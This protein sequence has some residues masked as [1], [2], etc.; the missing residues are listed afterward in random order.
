[1]A[2]EA[3][4]MKREYLSIRLTSLILGMAPPHIDDVFFNWAD[5][6]EE[7]ERQPE[8]WRLSLRRINRRLGGPSFDP[9]MGWCRLRSDGI[10][11]RR[12]SCSWMMP[13][14]QFSDE[15]FT[16]M[17]STSPVAPPTPPP[18]A[19]PNFFVYQRETDTEEHK[20]KIRELMP[21]CLNK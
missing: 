13:S 5:E 2:K 4:K 6:P 21:S 10:G 7:E 11:D 19:L 18:P 9:R 14:S 16:S 12:K 20:K 3:G 15:Q 17:S 1:M 8:E